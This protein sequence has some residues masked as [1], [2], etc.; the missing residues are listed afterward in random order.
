MEDLD[1]EYRTNETRY[2]GRADRRGRTSGARPRANSRTRGGREWADLV[3]G[4]EM[5]QVALALDEGRQLDGRTA[6]VVTELRARRRLSRRAG[7]VGGA[8]T[9][10]RRDR[11]QRHA[12]PDPD[13]A[14]HRPAVSRTCAAARMGAQMIAID[15]RRGRVAGGDVERRRPAGPMARLANVAGPTVFATTDAR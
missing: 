15:T 14:D 8:R 13:A 9:A 10:R 5:R 1:A 12:G 2:R 11:R 6:E 7:A 3:A 4:F